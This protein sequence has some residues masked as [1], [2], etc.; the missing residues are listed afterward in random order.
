MESARI[1]S[2]R[3]S[4]TC[5]VPPETPIW[6]I[7]ARIRSLAVTPAGSR[8]ATSTARVRGFFCSRHCVAST[9]PT[10]VVP[11]PKARAPNAPCV[12]VWLSPQTMVLPGCVMPSS[13]PMMC[14][15]PRRAS[16]MPSSSTPNSAQ[17]FS[18]CRICFAAESMVMGAPPNTCS[19]RVGVEWSIVARVRSG[20]RSLRPRSRSTVNACGEVTSCVRCRSTN[21]TAGVSADCGATS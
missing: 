21:S 15:I 10:S 6:P 12:E 1:A 11:M 7:N 13:G 9:C 8:P 5:P 16:C 4:R 2:P 14:T 3:Y 17:F 19:V 20:R 18:S